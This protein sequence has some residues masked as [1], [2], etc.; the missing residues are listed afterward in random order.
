[1]PTRTPC[2]SDDYYSSEEDNATHTLLDEERW[3]SQIEDYFSKKEEQYESHSYKWDNLMLRGDPED[4][5]HPCKLY[6]YIEEFYYNYS[7]SSHDLHDWL[8]RSELYI[9]RVKKAI[10]TFV[11]YL[12]DIIDKPR[13]WR[14]RY[15]IMPADSDV[16][17][18]MSSEIVIHFY[19]DQ[20]L[21]PY[22]YILDHFT[23]LDP[24]HNESHDKDFF[25]YEFLASLGIPKLLKYSRLRPRPRSSRI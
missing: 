2:E 6:H 20:H 25:T 5:T 21:N 23:F 4:T 12:E 9:E 22:E 7:C 11:H 1:M 14:S 13:L 19:D 15:Y 18:L 3:E 16:P 8:K 10:R 24:V 17:R